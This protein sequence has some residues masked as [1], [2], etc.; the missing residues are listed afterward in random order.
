MKRTILSTISVLAVLIS[1]GVIFQIVFATVGQSKGFEQSTGEYIIVTYMPSAWSPYI[2]RSG[3]LIQRSGNQIEY[4]EIT[5]AQRET[6][7]STAVA[8]VLTRLS[9]EGYVLQSTTYTQAGE[10][11]CFLRKTQ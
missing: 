1:A 11:H 4:V 7:I 8:G 6:T 3:I 2:N 9:Q 10:I 5:K